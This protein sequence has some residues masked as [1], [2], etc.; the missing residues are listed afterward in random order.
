M[1][2]LKF[3]SEA[4]LLTVVSIQS[5]KPFSPLMPNEHLCWELGFLVSIHTQLSMLQILEPSFLLLDPDPDSPNQVTKT[6]TESGVAYMEGVCKLLN[7]KETA[8]LA[9]SVAGGQ[10]RMELEGYPLQATNKCSFADERCFS[11]SR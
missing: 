6:G 10:Y 8:A 2:A 7:E 9:R 1:M 4:V 5:L 3:V 11:Q